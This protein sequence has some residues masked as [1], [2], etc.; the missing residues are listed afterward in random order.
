MK[1]KPIQ[2]SR[3]SGISP[4]RLVELGEG[5]RARGAPERAVEIVDPAVEGAHQR[6][7]ARALISATT[8]LPR[9]R[10]R[11]WKPRTTSS[12]PRTI[13]ARSPTTSMVR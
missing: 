1:M 10:Q 3:S 6:V 4:N 5:T 2:I 11:L 7:P 8:R 12:L 9:W 13:S